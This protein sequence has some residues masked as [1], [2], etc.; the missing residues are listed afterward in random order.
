MKTKQSDILLTVSGLADY[1]NIK[2]TTLY[3]KVEAG[4]IPSYKIGRLVRFKQ[5]EIDAWLERQKRG[6]VVSNRNP[7]TVIS[8][9]KGLPGHINRIIQ[10]GIDDVVHEGYN[11][12]HGKPDPV[13]GLRKEAKNGII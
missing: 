6:S 3:G 2:P 7:R 10:R 13:R 4:E 12:E 1:L 5:D 8:K 11:Q 9:G